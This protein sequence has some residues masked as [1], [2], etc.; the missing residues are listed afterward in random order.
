MS[1][2]DEM[3]EESELLSDDDKAALRAEERGEAYEEEPEAPPEMVE[4]NRELERELAAERERVWRLD[5]RRRVSEE[6]EAATATRQQQP[7]EPPS[8]LGERPDP[9]YDPIG[10]DLWD[11]RRET[12]LVR[13]GLEEQQRSAAQHEFSTWVNNDA[14]QFRAEHPDYDQATAHAYN[15]RVE[16]WKGLGLP[17]GKA[18]AIV[19]Q[20][21]V[22][23]AMLARQNGRSASATFYALAQKV[24]YQPN[25]TQQSAARSA[26]VR[27]RQAPMRGKPQARPPIDV[28]KLSEAQLESALRRNSRATGITRALERREL[29]GR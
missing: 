7:A 22:A 16:Y 5:E 19:D 10:A 29:L 27:Q 12:E 4:K 26:P 3:F 20:E 14:V 8:R 1:F 6:I 24:G 18:C 21:A 9:Y 13:M 15:F 17:E 23:T 25:G 28:D 11:V 2:I